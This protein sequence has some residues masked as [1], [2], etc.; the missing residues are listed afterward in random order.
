MSS[1]ELHEE[2]QEHAEHDH[3]DDDQSADRVAERER[4]G[5]G[6]QQ[7]DDEGIGQEAKKTDQPGKARL[8]HQAVRAIETQAPCRL[9]G[10]QAGRI[11]CSSASKSRSGLSQKPFSGVVCLSVP[12]LPCPD[13]INSS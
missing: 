4:N 8:A 7:D 10:R 11:G 9:I 5:A 13:N 6:H 1:L 2:V 12:I 3:R